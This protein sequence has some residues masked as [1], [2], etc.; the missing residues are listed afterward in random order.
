MKD[1]CDLTALEVEQI[2][3]AIDKALHKLKTNQQQLIY[4]CVEK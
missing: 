3:M 1:V 2:L 4:C